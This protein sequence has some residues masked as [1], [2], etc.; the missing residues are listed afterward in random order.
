MSQTTNSD[1]SDSANQREIERV[2]LHRLDEQHPDWRRVSWEAVAVELGLASIWQKAQP[3][4]VWKTIDGEV[5]I[6]ECYARVGELKA[7][8]RHKLAMDA[9]KLLAIQQALPAGN[10]VRY[11]LVMPEELMSR[12]EGGGWFPVALRLAAEIIPVNLMENERR[13]LMDASRRQAEG[14][15]RT[16]KARK[17]RRDG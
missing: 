11:L 5:I 7:G 8:H 1:P 10:H 2:M 13:E 15:A 16:K 14:Q 12:L 17:D 4:A 3:D 9:L 6:A